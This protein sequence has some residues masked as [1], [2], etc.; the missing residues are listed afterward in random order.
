MQSLA[1]ECN[2]SSIS[3]NIS[4]SL[5]NPEVHYCVYK[6]P[7]LPH[8]L[9]RWIKSTLYPPFSSRHIL[10]LFSHLYT[11]LPSG[12]FPSGFSHQNSVHISL[13]FHVCHML[14]P[15]HLPWHSYPIAILTYYIWN[16]VCQQLQTRQWCKSL[17]YNE[18]LLQ[19]F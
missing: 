8:T 11:C 6:A 7:Q 9:S 3:Q 5:P 4:Y 15:S 14:H 2:S 16:N 18:T 1:L 10:I 17:K 13:P 12:L 19:H